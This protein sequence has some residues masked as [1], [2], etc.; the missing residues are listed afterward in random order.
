MEN[1]G[2]DRDVAFGGDS[3]SD[4]LDMVIDPERL[5]D[6]DDTRITSAVLGLRD[7]RAHFAVG[8]VQ[9]HG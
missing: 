6:D 8:S 5:L 1:I 4:F 9:L 3:F 2:S 7:I